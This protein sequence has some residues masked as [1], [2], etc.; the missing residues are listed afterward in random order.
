MLTRLVLSVVL[1]AGIAGCSKRTT[2]VTQPRPAAVLQVAPVDGATSVRLDAGVELN[3][4]VAVDQA[5][6]ENGFHLISESDMAKNCPDSTMG[7]HG[8]MDSIMNNPGMLAHMEDFHA[9]RGRFS[10]N[11]AGTICTFAP[12]ILMEPQMR[13]MMQMNRTMLD[14]MSGMGGKMPAGQMTTS[15]DMVAHFITT[16]ADGHAGHH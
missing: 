7:N 11:T 3:F 1:V 15:G 16:T 5:V 12:D 13:Y 8:S 10:W 6:V 4:G 2:I 9:T 14:M